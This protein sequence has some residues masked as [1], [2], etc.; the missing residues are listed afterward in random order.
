M[1]APKVFDKNRRSSSLEMG[2]IRV[3]CVAHFFFGVLLYRRRDWMP[4]HNKMKESRWRKSA[5]V[6]GSGPFLLIICGKYAFNCIGGVVSAFFVD[7]S[8]A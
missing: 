4:R 8:E 2:L 6:R 3:F 5:I 1:K 7:G